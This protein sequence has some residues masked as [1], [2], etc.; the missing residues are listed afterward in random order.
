MFS[1]VEE[2]KS[3]LDIVEVIQG[4][5]K[6][7]KAG[8]N[9][10]GLCPFHSEKSPSFMVTPARQMWHCFGCGEGGDVFSFVQKVEGLEFADVLRMLAEKAGVKLQKQDPQ[11]QSQRKGSYEICELASRFFERQL[12]SKTGQL[13]LEY[14]KSRG[15]NSES[16]ENFRIGWA[17]DSWQSLRDFLRS[18]NYSDKEI[19]SA[20]LVVKRESGEGENTGKQSLNE[21]HDRFRHRIMFPICDSQGQVVG[22]SGRIFDKVKGKTVHPDAGK[23]INTPNTLLYNKS[24]ALYGID[25]AKSAIRDSGSCILVEGNLDVVMSHQAG[26][27]NSV[28]TCGTAFSQDHSRI[29]KRYTDKIFLAFDAD[30]AGDNALKKGIGIAMASGLSVSVISIP[31]GKDTADAVKENPS[32]W[33]ESVSKPVPYLGHLISRSMENF[34]GTLD[35]KKAVLANVLPFI[36]TIASPL[37]RDFWMEELSRKIGVSKDVLNMELKRAIPIDSPQQTS[38][39]VFLAGKSQDINNLPGL[40]QEEYLLSLLMRY[41]ELKKQIGDEELELFSQPRFISIAKNILSGEGNVASFADSSLVLLSEELGNFEIDANAEFNK[42]V[43]S[44]KKQNLHSKMK[45]IQSDIKKAETESDSASLE[46]LLK[47]FNELSR[48]LMEL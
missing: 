42:I 16:I 47:E 45:M 4:Y 2:I 17:P 38:Q 12:S 41:P 32:L 43:L 23:Y 9:W 20:G 10:K 21:Y 18:E 26:V 7:N 28:A 35:S 3:R 36:K 31:L 29:L 6:L 44:L 24:L 22:F 39:P 30:S 37:D 5:L 34:S 14:L 25:K 40:R 13:A 19:E 1:P 33:V 15:V 48:K 8:S 46:L 27:K 11:V